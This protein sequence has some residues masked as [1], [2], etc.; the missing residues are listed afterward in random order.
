MGLG[1]GLLLLLN[2]APVALT[3]VVLYRLG[4]GREGR[5]E[6]L[7]AVLIFGGCVFLVCAPWMARN[8]LRLGTP[9]VTTRGMKQEQMTAIAGLIDRALASEGDE[10]TCRQVREDVRA[11]CAEFPLPH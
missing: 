7:R 11:L 9:A 3:P 6:G 1:F 8:W 5:G 10:A 4:A 2:P